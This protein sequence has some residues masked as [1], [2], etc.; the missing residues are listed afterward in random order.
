LGEKFSINANGKLSASKSAIIPSPAKVEGGDG[1]WYN[2]ETGVAYAP[3]E[4][5]A[6]AGTYVA[7]D[8]IT[9]T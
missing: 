7:V 4:I 1:N 9:L 3:N 2:A 8:P 6:G 5:P